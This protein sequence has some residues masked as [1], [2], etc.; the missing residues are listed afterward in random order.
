MYDIP[1]GKMSHNQYAAV[2]SRYA[3][4]GKVTT[5]PALAGEYYAMAAIVSPPSRN[6]EYLRLAAEQFEK[7]GDKERAIICYHFAGNREK[8][9]M[10]S[11]LE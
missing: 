4:P 7:A 8:A 3:T 10:L 1:A 9:L 6:P 5:D 11:R 2:A